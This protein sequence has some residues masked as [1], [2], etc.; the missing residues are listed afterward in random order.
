MPCPS[1]LNIPE[2]F[3]LMNYHR[4][5]KL[6]DYAKENYAQIGKSPFRQ[7]KDASACVECGVC[8]EKCPQKLPIRQ[9]LKETHK[10]LA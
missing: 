9:Q 2:I 1:G 3:T 10:A 5:Y 6:T 8:E 4:V 7:Y